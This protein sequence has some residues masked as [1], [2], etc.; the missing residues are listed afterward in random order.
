MKFPRLQGIAAAV[1]VGRVLTAP[2]GFA[3]QQAC[4]NFIHH[5][6]VRERRTSFN[7]LTAGDLCTEAARRLL[8]E[9]RWSP[10]SVGALV[11]V[12]Q[13][14]DYLMPSTA[15]VLQERLELSRSCLA[16][17]MNLG[18]SGWVYG[19]SV[20]SSLM[21]TLRIQRALLLAGETAVLTSEDDPRSYPLMGDAGTATALELSD[22]AS[23]MQFGFYSDGGHFR[24]I[25]A[26]KSGA[27]HFA[28]G[29]NLSGLRYAAQMDADQVLR[30][31]L[32]DVVPDLRSFMERHG[33]Y[34]GNVDYFVLHQANQLINE[35]MRKKLNIPSEKLPYSIG[36]F[37]NTSSA[38]IPLTIVTQLEDQMKGEQ[39]LL[40]SGFGVGLSMAH[41]LMRTSAVICPPIVEVSVP[42]R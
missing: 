29:G 22:H 27:R 10:D 14:P 5:V 25:H 31:A 33:A 24:A 9:L 23:P 8:Q 17:D 2:T 19:L 13:S 4:D 21:Q 28:D 26:P 38:S 12:T 32:H 18:C 41:V 15:I 1:P 16:F 11:L 3:S 20:V 40:C 39:T 7:R 6:G 36:Q 35:T 30:F 34:E 42:V 37:G